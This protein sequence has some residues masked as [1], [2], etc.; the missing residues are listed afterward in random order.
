[1]PMDENNVEV[2]GIVCPWGWDACNNVTN[3]LISAKG[4]KD[5]YVFKDDRGD[6]LLQYCGKQVKAT[7]GCSTV[8]GAMVLRVS[9]FEEA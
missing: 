1:M 4:E 3:V 9:R 2:Q 8:K 6:A 5:Y 7:G